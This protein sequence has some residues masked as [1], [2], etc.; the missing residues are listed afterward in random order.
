MISTIKINDFSA[1]DAL[2]VPS[3]IIRKDITGDYLY[4]LQNKNG[5]EISAKKYIKRGLSNEGNTMILE[6]LNAGDKVIIDGYSL[7]SSGSLVAVE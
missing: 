7:V 2:V 6:G 1:K 4:V 3:I 5:K